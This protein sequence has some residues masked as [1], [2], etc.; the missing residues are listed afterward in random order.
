MRDSD[1]AIQKL[2]EL[3]REFVHEREWEKFHNPKD[4]A[5]AICIESAELLEIFQWISAEEASKQICDP[6]KLKR[7]EEEL[8]DILVYCLSLANVTD[9]DMTNAIV[10]KLKKNN[11][12]YP[13]EKYRGRAHL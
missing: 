6:S 13:V 2:K 3:V 10:N 12:K 11:V 8:A 1:I 4:L 7:I 9:I 5:E